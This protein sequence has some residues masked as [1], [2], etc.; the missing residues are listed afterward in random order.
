MQAAYIVLY[1]LESLLLKVTHFSDATGKQSR[2]WVA[3]DYMFVYRFSVLNISRYTWH[4]WLRSSSKPR[5]FIPLP[6]VWVK[7]H[8]NSPCSSRCNAAETRPFA[9]MAV[10]NHSAPCE[11]TLRLSP[12]AIS[13]WKGNF[14]CFVYE[15]GGSKNSTNIFQGVYILR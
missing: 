7:K 15:N 1:N 9:I 13:S 5:H 11:V 4:L 10:Q 2:G 12:Q 6:D 3:V 8:Q 14:R